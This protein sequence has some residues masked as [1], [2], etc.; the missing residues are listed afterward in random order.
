MRE[1]TGDKGKIMDSDVAR[2]VGIAG[3]S[4]YIWRSNEAQVVQEMNAFM[5]GLH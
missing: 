1:P 3:A 2:V 5:D 4:H